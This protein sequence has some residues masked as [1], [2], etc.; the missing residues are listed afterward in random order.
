MMKPELSRILAIDRKGRLILNHFD[1]ELDFI[2][3]VIGLWDET[4]FKT[5]DLKTQR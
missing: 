4:L 1:L 5:M 2:T 3:V